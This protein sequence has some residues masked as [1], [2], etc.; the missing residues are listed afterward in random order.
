MPKTATSNLD[1]AT[2]RKQLEDAQKKLRKDIVEK[3]AAHTRSRF[4]FDKANRN[5]QLVEGQATMVVR[6]ALMQEPDALV[7]PGPGGSS[8][9]WFWTVLRDRVRQYPSVAAASDAM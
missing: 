3:R 2:Q 8:E 5:L 1:F 7:I 9:N 6:T 4:A